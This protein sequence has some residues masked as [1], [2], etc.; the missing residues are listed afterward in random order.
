MCNIERV[1]DCGCQQDNALSFE[2]LRSKTS[3]NSSSPP[4]E[5]MPA[6]NY[7]EKEKD[8]PLR[9]MNNDKTDTGCQ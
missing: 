7:G 1:C 8:F 2:V 5:R 3:L 9:K 6:Q 4:H